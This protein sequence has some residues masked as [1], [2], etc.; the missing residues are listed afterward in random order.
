MAKKESKIFPQGSFLKYLQ[1]FLLIS[2]F[3]YDIKFYIL[4]TFQY[5]F[6]V[7]VFF[8]QLAESFGGSGQ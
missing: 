5:F 8:P 1:Y 4:E 7:A 2:S 6:T 3:L